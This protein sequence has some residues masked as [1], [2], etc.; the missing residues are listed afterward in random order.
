MISKKGRWG[1]LHALSKPSVGFELTLNYYVLPFNPSLHMRSWRNCFARVKILAAKARENSSKRLL[2]TL[3]TASQ[4]LCQNFPRAIK[5]SRR[6]RRLFQ[7]SLPLS[8][9][10]FLQ[11]TLRW[12]QNSCPPL[13][14]GARVLSYSVCLWIMQIRVWSS[15]GTEFFVRIMQ[16]G[17]GLL[18]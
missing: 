18:L 11:Y 13:R 2:P 4:L 17:K 12:F 1:E 7:S 3:R 10:F 8:S 5:R 15:K 16:R 9:S 6:L 14:G